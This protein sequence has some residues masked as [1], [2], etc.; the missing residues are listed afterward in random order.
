MS[1]FNFKAIADAARDALLADPYFS[2]ITVNGLPT[3]FI[4]SEDPNVVYAVVQKALSQV[5]IAIVVLLPACNNRN[6]N[7]PGPYFDDV[8]FHVKV[9]ELPNTNRPQ[10]LPDCYDLAANVCRVLHRYAPD[11]VDMIFFV[12]QAIPVADPDMIIYQVGIKCSAGIAFRANPAIGPVVATPATKSSSPQ[13]VTLTCSTLGAVIWYTLDGTY[14]SPLNPS[15]VLYLPQIVTL[16]SA[17][18]SFLLSAGGSVLNGLISQLTINPG[19]ILRARAWLSGYTPATPP[20]LQ[21]QY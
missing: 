13:V 7:E 15:S 6:P 21:I 3:P 18:G 10:G 8:L 5:N 16:D 1:A 14:P 4:F 12:S 2:A 9:F 19:Q 11:S 17:S 20:E